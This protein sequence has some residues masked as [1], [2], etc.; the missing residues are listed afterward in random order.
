METEP[1]TETGA[2]GAM[3]PGR[4]ELFIEIAGVDGS[5]GFFSKIE[6]GR[7]LFIDVNRPPGLRLIGE[8]RISFPGAVTSCPSEVGK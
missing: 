1:K 2:T 8:I 5:D 6:S 7:L 4:T 3:K